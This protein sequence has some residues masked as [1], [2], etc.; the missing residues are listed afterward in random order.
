MAQYHVHHPGYNSSRVYLQ[1][2]RQIDRNRE[3]LLLKLV[4]VT[5]LTYMVWTDRISIVLGAHDSD[6]REM[7][8]P[9]P[10]PQR[11]S[12]GLFDYSVPRPPQETPPVQLPKSALNN[13]TFAIDPSYARRYQVQEAEVSARLER[14]NHYVQKYAPVARAEMARCGI[15][16]SI[17]LAQGLLESNAGQSQLAQK[18]NN[19]FGIKCFSS[20]CKKGH[21]AN[22][23]DD[24]HKDFFVKYN[25]ARESFRAHSNFLKNG[26]RYQKLWQLN[27]NDYRAWARGLAKCGYATDK[28]YAE[29][30]M[31]I[32]Q[33]LH[34]EQFDE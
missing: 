34:L 33:S 16:A 27:S 22:F 9:Q 32:I 2:D 11:V 6:E 18:T 24:T 10:E 30:V 12:A 13:V 19:H 8:S 23:S 31:N 5:A 3:R 4:L 17:T 21:C 20:R 28:K 29:K 26:K 14:C 25:N 15:P 7:T 1:D